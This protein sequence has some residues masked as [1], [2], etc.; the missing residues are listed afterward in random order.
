M[1][2]AIPT[3][4][5][6][7]FK[8][9]LDAGS[10]ITD[11]KINEFLLE[12]DAII[13]SFIGTRYVTPVT[14]TSAVAQV[15]TVTVDTAVDST[16]YSIE[17]LSNGVTTSISIDSGVGATTT[18]IKDALVAAVNGD[19]DAPVVAEST[20]AATYTLTALVPGL[21]FSLTLDANQSSVAAT[22]NVA[23]SSA[24]FLLRKIEIDI[25]ACRVAKILKVKVA[26]RLQSSNV[27]QDILDGGCAS[28]AMKLLKM[29][30]DGLLDLGDATAVDTSGGMQSRNQVNSYL[31]QIDRE[32]TQ[33]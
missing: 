9:T 1:T 12:T 32:S 21:D 6:R 13:N 31:G 5:R 29:I 28:K 8:S 18:T 16:T 20:G 15:E 26:E 11:S 17:L 33:W 19:K 3:D 23:G 24:L 27:R 7:E 4:I 14:G 10:V 22:A 2:Y 25:V 30:K